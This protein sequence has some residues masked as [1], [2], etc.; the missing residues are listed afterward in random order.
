MK[1]NWVR[2]ARC[3]SVPCEYNLFEL[4]WLSNNILFSNQRPEVPSS[5][6]CLRQ[7]PSSHQNLPTCHRSFWERSAV[8]LAAL[9]KHLLSQCWCQTCLCFQGLVLSLHRNLRKWEQCVKYTSPNYSLYGDVLPL[10]CS[11]EGL[12]QHGPICPSVSAQL[13]REGVWELLPLLYG[14]P[15]AS[16]STE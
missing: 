6:L 10:F 15:L 5:P 16:A 4:L 13:Q 12:R 1:N 8:T 14:P 2:W 9:N 11:L 7:G 3:V